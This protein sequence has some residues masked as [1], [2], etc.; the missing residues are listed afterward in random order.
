MAAVVN[1]D[2]HFVLVLGLAV[3]LEGLDEVG[4]L[5]LYVVDHLELT[6]L[7]LCLHLH[8]LTIVINLIN[9]R[10][11]GLVLGENE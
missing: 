4:E 2:L 5:F 10:I 9:W 1:G 11:L 3:V 8:L 6:V 7:V